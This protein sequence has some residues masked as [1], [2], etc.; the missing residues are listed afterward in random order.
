MR[1]PL[2]LALLVSALVLLPAAA[3]LAAAQAPGGAR[4]VVGP[5]PIPEGEA[6]GEHD[7]TL[8]NKY[9]AVSIGV[10][11]PGPWG[12]P[13]GY[14]VDAAPV[15]DGKILQ[16]MLAQL[17]FLA[18][19]WGRWPKPDPASVSYGSNST[20]AW[21]KE[22][23]QWR[24]LSFE[25]T[26]FL[27]SDKPYLEITVAVTNKG[28]EPL[29]NLVQGFAMS[30][31][32]GWVFVPG[33]GTKKH[34]K[35]T[36]LK[37]LGIPV[38]AKWVAGY[39][40]DYAVG[41]IA[42]YYTHLSTS[43]SWVDPLTIKTI[44]PGETVVY[45]ARLVFI[46]EPD[47]C[48]IAAMAQPAAL[49]RVEGL[50]GSQGGPVS[51]AYVMA[52]L[53]GGKPFCWAYSTGGKYS[54]ELPAGSYLLEAWARSHGP[55]TRRPV[56]IAPGEKK[57]VNLTDMKPG[58][59][60]VLHVAVDG[61]PADAAIMPRGGEKPPLAFLGSTVYYTEPGHMG[62]AVL[63][64][65]PGSYN[66][67]ISH[68][69]GYLAKPVTI[70]VVVKPGE[71]VEK[72]VDIK[73]LVHPESYG[74][75]CADLHHHS[76]WADGRTPPAY[77]VVAQSAAGLDFAFV[78]D[79]DYIGNYQAIE[80]YA[81]TRGMPFIP[82]VEVSPGWGHF[83]VYPLPLELAKEKPV[84]PIKKDNPW[85][86]IADAYAKGAMVIRVNHPLIGASGYFKSWL[87]GN[88]PGPYCPFYTNVEINGRWDRTDNE[89]LRFMWRMWD[90]NLRYYLTAGSDTHDVFTAFTTGTPRVCAYLGD[91]V[92][93][94]AFAEA[95][96]HGHT[97]ITYGPMVFM[98]PPPGS[99]V[100]PGPDGKVRITAT[101]YAVNGLKKLVVVA[102]G[103]R[104]LKTLDLKGETKAKI[105]LQIPYTQLKPTKN[106]E[107]QA[108]LQL[109]VYDQKDN[110][111]LTNPIW[112][113]PPATKTSHT[114][115]TTKT[116]TLTQTATKT[117]T[118]T[119]TTTT[120]LTKTSYQTTTRTITRTNT[121]TT[122]AATVIAFIAGLAIALLT[123]RH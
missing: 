42:P 95:E 84:D 123:R 110:R 40:D 10:S 54:M 6:N 1:R 88:L 61:K 81:E 99:T 93:V 107:R 72:S 33:W 68:G 56:A 78:S 57:I 29:K 15:K 76:D 44:A 82:S 112:V 75:Y 18:D 2:L 38:D 80:R 89:T 104:I 118:V 32:R 49:G 100:A 65:A 24:T 21:L 74:Y 71:T 20:G 101:L 43:T 25:I 105:Q 122:A 62:L 69:G 13:R 58:G 96:L 73:Q 67:T 27:P 30:L 34:Y 64:L 41:L 97:F 103:G 9:L 39:A 17:S 52:Y 19:G 114:Q 102:T 46:P 12:V 51:P 119:E 98:Q 26:Y 11:T 47:T 87:T 111:A 94:K 60:L 70:H 66:V 108:W 7:V 3:P 37:E 22:K 106:T 48:T 109:I 85:S 90:D 28:S 91:N 92:T 14:I 121:A 35:P 36:P 23:A 77:L 86:L 31:E 113:D 59:R 4:V 50:V 79:H 55:S 8:M 45:K 115:A 116:V 16:D 83:N 53:G 63:N 117:T 5:T 120:T